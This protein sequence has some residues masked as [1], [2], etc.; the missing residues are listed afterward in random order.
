MLASSFIKR[1]TCFEFCPRPL[2]H[3]AR[4]R[5]PEF[6]EKAG[7]MALA[8]ETDEAQVLAERAYRMA[9]EQLKET[10]SSGRKHR[11]TQGR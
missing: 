7:D 8:V 1:P 10:M 2:T 3:S 5:H 11:P 6:L 9:S 4:R